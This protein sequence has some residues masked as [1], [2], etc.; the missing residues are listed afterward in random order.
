MR[1]TLTSRHRLLPVALL[2]V[3]IG[4]VAVRSVIGGP[5]VDHELAAAI[6][7][8]GVTPYV[9][10]IDDARLVD[11]DVHG[12]HV[13][14]EYKGTHFNGGGVTGDVFITV[15][16]KRSPR[17]DICG[18]MRDGPTPDGGS[19]TC[20][21]NR[22]VSSFEEMS[23]YEELKGDTLVSLSFD[24]TDDT[25]AFAALDGA[26]RVSVDELARH[27]DGHADD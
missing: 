3:L 26:R 16:L 8:T 19:W 11:V 13:R 24:G 12:D 15:G 7:A 1:R 27:S 17:N 18:H 22:A 6:R 20:K 5:P 4:V 14:L 10:D 2:A 21:D 25:K 9:L 23:S